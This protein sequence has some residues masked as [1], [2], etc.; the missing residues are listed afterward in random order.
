M[1]A[2]FEHTQFYLP[3]THARRHGSASIGAMI[4][5]DTPSPRHGKTRDGR[6]L[7]WLAVAPAVVSKL[8]GAVSHAMCGA[9]READRDDADHTARLTAALGA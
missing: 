9:V 2:S 5:D 1:H 8:A 3:Y 6:S 4:C 7:A